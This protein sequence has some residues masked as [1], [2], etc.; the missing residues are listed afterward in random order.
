MPGGFCYSCG[1]TE[2]SFVNISPGADFEKRIEEAIL[3]LE[4]EPD[5]NDME[6]TVETSRFSLSPS[7]FDNNVAEKMYN[8]TLQKK[9]DEENILHGTD[10]KGEIRISFG[11]DSNL[12]NFLIRTFQYVNFNHPVLDLINSEAEKIHQTDTWMTAYA[13]QFSMIILAYKNRKLQLANSFETVATSNR[14]Y[15]VLNIWTML[16]MDVL[17]DTLYILGTA[18]EVK[19]LKSAVEDFIKNVI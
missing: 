2:P 12:Y 1:Q 19:E 4:I 18:D 6:I 14:A 5:N 13:G 11:I 9:E 10:S 15:H 7:S 8:L 16:D 3:D 17:L